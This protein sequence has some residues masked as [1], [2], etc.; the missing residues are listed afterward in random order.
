PDYRIHGLNFRMNEFTAAIGLVQTERLPEI[1]AWKNEATR[2]HIDP[3]Y[4]SRLHLP[5][6]M[7]SG[8]YKAIVFEPIEPSTGK[9]SDEP[10]H[11]ILG[12]AVDLPNSDWVAENH[13]CVPLYYHPNVEEAMR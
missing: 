8:L 7:V 9:R 10:C 6:R 12:H 13:W 5:D 4:S 1:V 2:L 3:V 11:R